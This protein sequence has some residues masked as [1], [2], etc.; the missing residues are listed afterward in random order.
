MI[1]N[2]LNIIFT[3]FL[4][5]AGFLLPIFF[6][7]YFINPLLNSK[8]LIL[9]AIAIISVFAFVI[10]SLNNKNWELI[11]TPFTFPLIGFAL[12]VI[13]SSLV[14]NQYPIKQL[15]GYGGAYLSFAAIIL[16]IPLL[17]E[18]KLNKW[19]IL[20]LNAAAIFI[21]ILSVFQLFG[22]GLSSIIS[23]LSIQE[24][25]NTLA[26]SLT[27]ST[28]ISIQFLSAVLF[29]NIFDQKSWK[30][31]WSNKIV[32]AIIAIALSINIW[33]VF[34][35]GE[36]AFQSLSFIGSANVAKNSLALT[37]NAL[38]GY[39]P[40][41]YSNA[42]NILKPIWINGFNYWRFNFD[43][44]FNF[45]LT[46]IVSVGI[47]GFLAYLLFLWKAFE[48]IKNDS[49]E[50]F[51]K[52]FI[53]CSIIWQFFAPINLVM[54]GLLAISFGFFVASNNDRYK[55]ISFRTPHLI[56]FS[57]HEVL[58]PS[59]RYIFFGSN[60]AILL[61]LAIA[62]YVIARTFT[63]FYLLYKSSESISK[64]E[65]VKA[66]DSH[67]KAKNLAPEFD[68][69]RRSSSLINLQIAIALSNKADIN[70]A[71]QDQVIKLVN[72]SINEAKAATALEPSNYQNWVTLAQIYMQ[73]LNTTEQAQQEAF[74]A[75]ARAISNNPN[76]PELR[77]TLGQ[78]FLNNK[79]NTEAITFF[80]QAIERKPDLFVAHYYLAQALIADGQLKEASNSLISSLNLLDKESSDYATIEKELDALGEKIKEQESKAESKTETSKNSTKQINK[81]P[82]TQASES[83]S[84]SN[85]LDKQDTE[86]AI[87]NGALTSDQI[88]VNN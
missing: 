46:I 67:Q 65:I 80:N 86:A 88:L 69:I 61:G 64:N 38:F 10:K 31:S 12:I 58:T 14:S 78:L 11:K 62:S 52:S 59:K 34:P 23:R 3:W 6:F 57:H 68:F 70:Q 27:G 71:E 56:N 33:S 60:I 50:P 9:L 53:F 72:Q 84:L 36:G 35:G 18:K 29:S 66:Y 17:I 4:V 85:L 28:F 2:K 26:F 81:V 30:E 41:S 45:P 75:L 73:L 25:P 16:L 48:S 32:T 44:A 82:E 1:K 42:Y 5:A 13:I 47:I 55:K 15:I 37:R 8:L 83:S 40:D 19:F 49:N 43:S 76:N 21:S 79:K 7:P 24:L 22:L 87:Q 20:S 74:N 39:G 77:I 54:L 51:L 63:A